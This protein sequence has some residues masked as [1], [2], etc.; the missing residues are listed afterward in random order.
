[1][2][3]WLAFRATRPADFAAFMARGRAELGLFE[4]PFV[5]WRDDVALF[6][7]PR[8]AG[9]SALS[10]EDLTRVEVESR[11]LMASHLA[12]Y[13][14]H[15]PGFG[16]AYALQMAPQVGARHSR[17]IAGVARM[18]RED[19]TAGTVHADEVGI[20]PSPALSVPNVSVRLG[21]LVPR[22][23]SNLLAPGKHLASDPASHAFMREIPQCW[24]TGQAAG[25]A[26]A[27]AAAARTDL[28]A[29]PIAPLRRALRG[30]GVVL[31]GGDG[32]A[33]GDAAVR[34]R[35]G[36]DSGAPQA[37]VAGRGDAR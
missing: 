9:L 23:F 12:F 37:V 28:R 17:R 30:Q 19:W 14:A 1:M 33:A 32:E 34:A 25:V 15:A 3:A 8:R 24:L 31:H 11:D 29:L 22:R 26:A 20:S 13:R 2:R 10:L 16:R 35:S 5:S 7:G 27:Q 6:M 36:H 4:K 18:S 21:A